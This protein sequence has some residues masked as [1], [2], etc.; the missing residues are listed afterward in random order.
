MVSSETI[1][2]NGIQNTQKESIYVSANSVDLETIF[3]EF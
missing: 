2:K 3:L 1:L